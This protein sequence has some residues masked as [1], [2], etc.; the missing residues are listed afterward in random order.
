MG[1]FSRAKN[2]LSNTL[3]PTRDTFKESKKIGKGISSEMKEGFSFMKES[4]KEI[5]QIF[6]SN[7]FTFFLLFL[8]LC[9]FIFLILFV[10]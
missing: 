7:F 10:L 8:I 9:I 3:K 2:R 4:K 5:G 1:L 6:K